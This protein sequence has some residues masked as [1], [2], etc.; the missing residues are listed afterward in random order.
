MNNSTPIVVLIFWDVFVLA[1]F[2]CAIY[3][4]VTPA[5][6]LLEWD[7]CT[8]Y[9]IYQFWPKPDGNDDSAVKAAGWFYKIFGGIVAIVLGAQIVAATSMIVAKLIS[10]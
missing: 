9:R 3:T 10:N 6:K 7:R 4:V 8:G 5:R 2:A 1:A